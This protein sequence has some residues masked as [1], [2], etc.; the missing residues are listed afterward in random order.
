MSRHIIRTSLVL[1][2]AILP[3][4]SSLANEPRQDAQQQQRVQQVNQQ[5]EEQVRK[6]NLTPQEARI[7]KLDESKA[8]QQSQSR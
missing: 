1:A 7:L 3:I 8:T 2:A 4:G 6:G 5:V